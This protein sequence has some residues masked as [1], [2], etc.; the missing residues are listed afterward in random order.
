MPT[1]KPNKFVALYSKLEAFSVES[2]FVRKRP[3]GPR[4]TVFVNKE[5]PQD[6]W[7][8]KKKK[9]KQEHTYTSNQVI[10]SKYS[11]ITFLPRNLLEQF[12]RLAN[13]CVSSRSFA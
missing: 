3:P 5:V 7:D 9:V 4:R 1:K 2:L 11:I 8:P 12:R 6:Y 10:T 13:V